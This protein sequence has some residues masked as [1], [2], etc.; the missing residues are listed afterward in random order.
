MKTLLKEIDLLLQSKNE[1][2]SSLEWWNK[3][4]EEENKEIK[5]KNEALENDL[6]MYQEN[7]E[8]LNEQLRELRS[9]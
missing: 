5:A 4:L 1:K 3:H 7:E 6:K 9:L 8:K 2:I